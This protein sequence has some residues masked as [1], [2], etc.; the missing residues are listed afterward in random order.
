MKHVLR[1]ISALVAFLVVITAALSIQVSAAINYRSLFVGGVFSDSTDINAS[2]HY[3]LYVPEDYDPNISYP[4]ILFLH[5][6]AERGSS[7]ASELHT[8]KFNSHYFT[9]ERMEKYPCIILAPQCP[10]RSTWATA[11]AGDTWTNC[12]YTFGDYEDSAYIELVMNLLGKIEEEY[13]VDSTRR[14]ITGVSMGGYGTW[15]TIMKY[16]EY[17]AA[18]APNCGGM[19][20]DQAANLTELPIWSFHG[21]QDNTVPIDGDRRMYENMVAL[22]QTDSSVKPLKYVE[23]TTDINTESWDDIS[24]ATYIFTEYTGVGHN[25][26]LYSYEEEYFYDWMFSKTNEAAPTLL[27]NAKC[28]TNYAYKGKLF[29]DGSL[30]H[31]NENTTPLAATDDNMDTAWYYSQKAKGETYLGIKWDKANTVDK[32]IVYWNKAT[33]ATASDE[34]Y[35]IQ[36]SPDGKAWEDVTGATYKYSTL[37][38]GVISDVVTFDAIEAKAMRILIRYSVGSIAP[39]IFEIAIYNTAEAV[40][41]GSMGTNESTYGGQDEED[42]GIELDADKGI[43]TGIPPQTEVGNYIELLIKDA[44]GN[45]TDSTDIIGTGFTVTANGEEYTVII[46]GDVNGDGTINSSDFTQV[47]R[48]FIGLFELS[49]AASRAADVDA[50]GSINSTDFM[51]IRAHFLERINLFE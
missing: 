42:Y 17:F 27:N 39:K 50:D 12:A 26:S 16:S 24:Q 25:C 37:K 3:Q 21:D 34:G 47:R 20:P 11:T 5:G 19:D 40:K 51:Q 31:A 43:V 32:F 4:I 49:D 7:D 13:N 38:G 15:A 18:A 6:A 46:K 36:Y 10:Y 2:I 33:R 8:T 14:Y 29:D 44:K 9:E 1:M 23:N 30:T 35:V 48:T 41:N 45:I 22:S 28:A